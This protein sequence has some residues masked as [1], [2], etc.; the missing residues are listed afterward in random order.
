MSEYENSTENKEESN[1]SWQEGPQG[2][3]QSPWQDSPQGFDPSSSRQPDGREEDPYGQYPPYEQ[4]QPYGRSY[5]NDP[6]RQDP[7]YGRENPEDPYRQRQPYDGQN[8]NDPYRQGSSYGRQDQPDNGQ[9][10]RKPTNH[11]A[12][13]SLAVGIFG[14]LSLCCMAFPIAIILGVGA[15]SFAV[16]SRQGRPFSGPAIAGIV[17]GVLCILLGIGEFFYILAVSAFMRDPKNAAMFN[18]LYEQLQSIK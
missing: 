16:L 15:I 1:D 4:N 9:P 2:A 14:L 13:V 17:L 12:N 3:P 10:P 18:A 5:P 7:L 6:Y 8:P 11:F